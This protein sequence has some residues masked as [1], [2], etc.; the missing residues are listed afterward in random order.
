M[1]EDL[2]NSEKASE[3]EVLDVSELTDIDDQKE[4]CDVM[5]KNS[6]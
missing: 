2:V 1:S 3:S 4:C 6:F 5:G